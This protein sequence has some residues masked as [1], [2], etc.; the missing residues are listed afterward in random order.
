M[1]DIESI[2]T[3]LYVRSYSIFQE[4]RLSRLDHL[5]MNF[6][7][8]PTSPVIKCR[9]LGEVRQ[10]NPFKT[11]PTFFLDKKIQGQNFIILTEA[12]L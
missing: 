1:I 10:K 3:N 8:R 11:N 6:L 5:G 12:I 7:G 9:V 2:F 4:I